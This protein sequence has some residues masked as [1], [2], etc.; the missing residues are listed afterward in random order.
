MIRMMPNK[1]PVAGVARELEKDHGFWDLY[2]DRTQRYNTPHRDVSDI[3]LRFNPIRNLDRG[4]DAFFNGEHVSE[5]YPCADS[6][7][8][9]KNLALSVYEDVGGSQLGGVLITKI[10]PGGM[11]RPHKDGGWHAGFYEKFAV[12]VKGDEKQS[13]NFE[14]ASLS[15]LSGELYTFDNS[16]LHWVF[17]D[18]DVD[19]I[20]MIVCVKR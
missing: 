18:S 16:R 19:R 15:P 5:W 13:F 17:N 12:Q 20:T 8:R 1:Y 10:P 3:W 9:C 14:D 6:L 4:R 7:T 11:V 2:T